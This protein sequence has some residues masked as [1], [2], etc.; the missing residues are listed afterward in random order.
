MEILIFLYKLDIIGFMKVIGLLL[1]VTL[2]LFAIK[3]PRKILSFMM[4]TYT[5]IIFGSIIGFVLIPSWISIILGIVMI[6][7][8]FFFVESFFYYSAMFTI[9]FIF[10]T[11]IIYILGTIV[12]NIII[13]SGKKIDLSAKEEICLYH[14]FD[15]QGYDTTDRL[16]LVA[17]FMAMIIGILFAKLNNDKIFVFMCSVIGAIQ[18]VGG[19]FSYPSIIASVD[20][21]REIECW[22]TIFIPMLN[23]EFE[24]LALY[25]IMP[26]L[27]IA[28]ICYIIQTK[29]IIKLLQNARRRERK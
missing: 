11:D 21:D 5:A 20:K 25:M 9:T 28:I 26:I 29:I 10:V 6:F 17:L 3:I 8:I 22:E 2:C 15:I 12:C 16:L 23:I 7:I 4:C 24:E 19:I 1:G 27:I 14:W 13:E 18:I